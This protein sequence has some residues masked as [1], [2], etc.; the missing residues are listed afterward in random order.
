MNK[1]ISSLMIVF[2]VS[3]LL[4]NIFSCK[5][6]QNIQLPDNKNEYEKN[7]TEKVKNTSDEKKP[8]KI[9]WA[10]TYK[11]EDESHII[12][13]IIK[14]NNKAYFE[15]EDPFGPTHKF[16]CPYEL[17]ENMIEIY[18]S[19][20]VF[21]KINIKKLIKNPKSPLYILSYNKDVL[22]TQTQFDTDGLESKNIYFRKQ[23]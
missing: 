12:T 8:D 5:K 16:E 1:N 14:P 21:D 7:I 3:G 2:L 6:N 10:G 20:V 22:Y 4:L 23:D 15:G 13:L 17:K 18:F 19:K 11:Y 9:S